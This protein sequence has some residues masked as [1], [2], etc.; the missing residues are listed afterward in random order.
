VLGCRS[1]K[2]EEF[3]RIYDYRLAV[4]KVNK[5]LAEIIQSD[6][7]PVVDNLW[8]T[9]NEVVSLPECQVR[10]DSSVCMELCWVE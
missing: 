7:T 1:T 6:G 2:P 9:I 4:Q 5:H 3:M 8:G 10:V